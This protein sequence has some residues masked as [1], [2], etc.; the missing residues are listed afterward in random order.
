LLYL[1]VILD[2]F[3]QRVA[4]EADS[5]RLH[6]ELALEALLKSLAIQR[7]GKGLIHYSDLSSQYCSTVYQAELMKHGIRIPMSEKGNCFDNAV[8]ETFL[9]TVKEVIWDSSS[10][11]PGLAC[12]TEHHCVSIRSP[13]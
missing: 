8:A 7:S 6:Q 9:N 4:G 10:D 5:D 11:R 1:A 12:S 2:L 13:S 3:A